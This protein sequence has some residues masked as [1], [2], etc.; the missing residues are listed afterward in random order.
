MGNTRTRKHKRGGAATKPTPSVTS[1]TTR[2][3]TEPKRRKLEVEERDKKIA[4]LE[5]QLAEKD[6]QEEPTAKKTKKVE[7]R[8]VEPKKENNGTWLV[9]KQFLRS[10]GYNFLKYLMG[11]KDEVDLM[12]HT[13]KHTDI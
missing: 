4:E 6:K 3:T 2:S 10:D 7:K 13:I 1:P 9:L 11:K 5:K 8:K 12:L